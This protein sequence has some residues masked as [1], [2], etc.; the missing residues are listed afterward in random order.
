MPSDR[1]VLAASVDIFRNLA[2]LLFIVSF[3]L[4]IIAFFKGSWAWPGYVFVAGLACRIFAAALR[5]RLY[6]R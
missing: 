3:A 4:L 5:S 1:L 6:A 2:Y